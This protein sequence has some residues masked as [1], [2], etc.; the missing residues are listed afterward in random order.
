MNEMG[1]DRKCKKECFYRTTFPFRGL[2]RLEVGGEK[3]NFHGDGGVEM[4]AIWQ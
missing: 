3:H 2:F 4:S 1:Q